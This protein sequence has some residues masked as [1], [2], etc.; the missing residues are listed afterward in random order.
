VGAWLVGD[1]LGLLPGRLLGPAFVE[2]LEN[3]AGSLG[4]VCDRLLPALGARVP[5]GEDACRRPGLPEALV[6]LADV[7]DEVARRPDHDRPVPGPGRRLRVRRLADRDDDR[8]LGLEELV[9]EIGF[10]CDSQLPVRGR[11]EPGRVRHVRPAEERGDLGRHLPRL[12]VERL[13]PAEHDV[14]ALL[15]DRDRERA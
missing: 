10:A 9:A 3:R 12:R 15:P 5:H 7:V 4:D 13:A 2:E 8:Q 6:V 14:G 1:V 11:L